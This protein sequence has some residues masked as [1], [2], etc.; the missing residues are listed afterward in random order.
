LEVISIKNVTG[1]TIRIWH[2]FLINLIVWTQVKLK[3]EVT[4]NLKGIS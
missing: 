2:F 1:P 4:T 3:Y